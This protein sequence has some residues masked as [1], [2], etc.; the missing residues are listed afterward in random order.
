MCAQLAEMPIAL[1]RPLFG[2]FIRQIAAIGG[3]ELA[4]CLQE[5]KRIGGRIG[6][7]LCRRGLATQQQCL[8]ALDNQA[9][10]VARCMRADVAS[11][12]LPYPAFLSL[13]MPAFNEAD[14]IAGTLDAAC[15]TLP[16]FV[17]DFEVVVVDD[18]SSDATAE[19]V[20]RFA[21]EHPQVRLVSHSRNRGYG[22]AVS[23]GLRAAAG[24]LIMFTDSDGQFSLLDL[25]IFLSRLKDHD[26]VVGYRFD[27]ADSAV[28]K[29]NAWAWTKLID[30]LF[31]VPIRDLDCAFKLFR[32]EDIQGMQMNTRGAA[33]NAEIMMQCFRRG[34]R[35]CELPVTHYACYAGDQ[36]GANLRVILRAFRE[37]SEVRKSQLALRAEARAPMVTSSPATSV[38]LPEGGSSVEAQPAA[39]AQV[40]THQPG[41]T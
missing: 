7:I 8:E 39:T 1:E 29:F 6:E 20:Q 23:T 19:T 17:E 25:P 30:L 24:D 32:R 13:C 38:V 22:A 34:L 10:W 26:V 14:T 5:Q 40:E 9:A 3:E 35:V 15:V 12:G 36:T 4:S 16:Y 28:R 31:G 37:L 2:Q 27:R 33:I 18:G 21:D 11:G 41:R